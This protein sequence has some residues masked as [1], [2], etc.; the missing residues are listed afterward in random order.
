MTS[1]GHGLP[2]MIPVRNDDRSKRANSGWSS[3]AMN[4]V[5]TP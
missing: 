1:I 3:C 4:I 5:G 2:A